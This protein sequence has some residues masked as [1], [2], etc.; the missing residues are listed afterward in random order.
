MPSTK[1]DQLRRNVGVDLLRGM[2]I[3]AVVLMHVNIRVPYKDTYVGGLLPR[4]LH[5]FLFWDGFYGV[6]VFFVISGYVITN[7]ALQRWGALTS[8][9]VRAFYTMRFARIMPLLA[10]VLAIGCVLHWLGT[11]K[12][13]IKPELTSLPRALIAALTFH[14][15]WLQIQVGHLPP[16]WGVL[17]SLSIEE[18]F[19]LVFPLLCLLAGREWHFVAAVSIF[20]V[21]SPWARVALFSD[22]ELGDHN[23]L[24]YLDSIAIGCMTALAAHRIRLSKRQ[25]LGFLMLGVSMMVF[26]CWFRSPVFHLGLTK[27]GLYITV[28]SLGTA[29]VLLWMHA[30]HARG[31]GKIPRALSWLPACG[32]Y[33]YEIYLTHNFVVVG[34][35]ALFKLAPASDLSVN[36]LYLGALVLSFL[37]GSTVARTISEP[38]NRKLRR[39]WLGGKMG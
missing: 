34:A 13:T 18:T 10:L 36:A 33:S 15:N 38:A 7:S 32:T 14:I 8:L 39:R 28:L 25:L 21:V 2:S 24:A 12:F 37:L 30:R 1:T 26:V 16:N 29:F 23:H 19:Y 6:V 9:D 5:D 31:H 22:N 3:V 4:D 20:L 27:N 17:W 35:V 11:P